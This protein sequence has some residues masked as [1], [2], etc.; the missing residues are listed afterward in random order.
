MRD[1][2]GDT[3]EEPLA[4]KQPTPIVSQPRQGPFRDWNDGVCDCITDCHSCAFVAFC[5]PCYMCYLYY[6][7]NECALAPLINPFS[8]TTLRSFHRGR[9]RIRVSDI[10]DS[11]I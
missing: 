9:E 4:L 11:T 1:H 10:S 7:Y 2:R 5:M 8:V 6:R 3:M